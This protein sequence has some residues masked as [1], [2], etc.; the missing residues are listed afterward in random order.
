MPGDFKVVRIKQVFRFNSVR[1]NE[2]PLYV[3]K[4]YSLVE[5]KKTKVRGREGDGDR[6]DLQSI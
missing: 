2:V 4:L 6:W 1:I 5:N 3:I